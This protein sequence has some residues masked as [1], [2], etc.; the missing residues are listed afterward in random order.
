MVLV[1]Q[2]REPNNETENQEGVKV[3]IIGYD[4]QIQIKHACIIK[5]KKS[6]L[7]IDETH[8]ALRFVA[9]LE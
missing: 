5:G 9:I 6:K 1:G 3:Y 7:K 8:F 4:G 2:K